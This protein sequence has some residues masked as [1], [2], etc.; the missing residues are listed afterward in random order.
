[1]ALSVSEHLHSLSLVTDSSFI[2]DF[3]DCNL[4]EYAEDR[5]KACLYHLSNCLGIGFG[6]ECV[7]ARRCN[8]R[9]IFVAKRQVVEG[10]SRMCLWIVSCSFFLLSEVCLDLLACFDAIHDRHLDV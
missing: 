5:I 4:V 10:A 7:D 8:L 3:L 6:R 2:E 1:M 9:G